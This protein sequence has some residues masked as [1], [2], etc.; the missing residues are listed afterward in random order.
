MKKYA[1][2]LIKDKFNALNPQKIKI[3]PRMH[4]NAQTRVK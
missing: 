3:I 2:A 4:T 1:A